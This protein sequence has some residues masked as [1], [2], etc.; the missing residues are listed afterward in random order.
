[1]FENL[2]NFAGFNVSAI[3]FASIFGL[4]CF[5]IA[6][7][8]LAPVMGPIFNFFE[9]IYDNVLEPIINI[10]NTKNKQTSP[11]NST[12]NSTEKNL[13]DK[14]FSLA[15][16]W[17]SKAFIIKLLIIFITFLTLNYL[18]ICLEEQKSF[19]SLNLKN[20][21]DAFAIMVSTSIVSLGVSLLIVAFGTEFKRS[22]G[23]SLL[24]FSGIGLIHY[25]F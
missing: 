15:L 23:L 20:I 14:I 18:F 22:I 16:D 7:Y 13:L 6:K 10:F 19:L 8:V 11:E 2:N 1:M 12:K 5:F 17:F 9:F 21:L 24:I 25:F 3:L 4:I